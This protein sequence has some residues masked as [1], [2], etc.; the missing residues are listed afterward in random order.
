MCI[1]DSPPPFSSLKM[2]IY[3]VC[4]F[5]YLF[6][7]LLYI[8]INSC[9]IE[10]N[11]LLCTIMVSVNDLHVAMLSIRSFWNFSKSEKRPLSLSTFS[12]V[13]PP[14]AIFKTFLNLGQL[15]APELRC[16]RSFRTKTI[17]YIIPLSYKG[18]HCVQKHKSLN[19]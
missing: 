7:Y 1:R 8:Y 11:G 2:C 13:S 3:R 4:V 6:I 5:I 12:I 10:G 14:P 19:K 15:F 17:S 16:V 9:V 18:D